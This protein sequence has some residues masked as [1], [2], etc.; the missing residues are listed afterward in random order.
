M[1]LHFYLTFYLERNVYISYSHAIF[2]N[3][4]KKG[5]ISISRKKIRI[6]HKGSLKRY[7]FKLSGSKKTQMKAIRKADK[8]YGKGEVDRKLAALESFNKH[9]PEKRKRVKA[10]IKSNQKS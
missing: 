3:N 2:K 1:Y 6:K 5:V 10:L 9:H 8:H 7:G 4:L